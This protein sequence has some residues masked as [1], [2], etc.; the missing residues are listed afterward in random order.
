M[1]FFTVV[2]D[3]GNARG[4]R[5]S[6]GARMSH[7]YNA[8]AAKCG[9]MYVAV[10]RNRRLRFVLPGEEELTHL[11]SQAKGFET[12]EEAEEAAQDYIRRRL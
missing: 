8:E 2:F 9:T 1:L 5:R 7:C 10:V 6:K 11:K 3:Q 4:Q 12:E